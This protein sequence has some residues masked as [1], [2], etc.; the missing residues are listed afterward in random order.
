MKFKLLFL[1]LIVILFVCSDDINSNM[2]Q[3]MVDFE[4]TAQDESML[5]LGDFKADWWIANN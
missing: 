1:L 2:S 3:T 4:F 5:G